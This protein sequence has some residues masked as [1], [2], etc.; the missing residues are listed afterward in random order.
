MIT[1]RKPAARHHQAAAPLPAWRHAR[2]SGTGRRPEPMGRAADHTGRPFECARTVAQPTG[3]STQSG[4]DARAVSS[5]TNHTARGWR[6][7]PEVPG[8]GLLKAMPARWVAVRRFLNRAGVKPG[9][10]APAPGA[11]G[12]LGRPADRGGR[13]C[14]GA[15]WLPYYVRFRYGRAVSRLG[16]LF[17]GTRSSCPGGHLLVSGRQRAQTYRGSMCGWAGNHA[18]RGLCSISFGYV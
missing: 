12:L 14:G 7:N 15:R 2:A 17:G 6:T 1:D 5:W 18:Q 11:G 3:H 16:C 4:G 10:M 8:S 13:I 9:A